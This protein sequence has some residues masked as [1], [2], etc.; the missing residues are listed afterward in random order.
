MK[1]IAV[2]A[3]ALA[4]VAAWAAILGALARRQPP[5]SPALQ[6]DNPYRKIYK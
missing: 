5:P 3:A 2:F 4:A 6:C 1:R